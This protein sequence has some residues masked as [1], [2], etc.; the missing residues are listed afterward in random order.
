VSILQIIMNEPQWWEV[1]D[2]EV[3]QANT[4]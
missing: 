2:T 4:M 3:G 1:S